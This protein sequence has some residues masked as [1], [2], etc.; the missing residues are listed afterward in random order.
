MVGNTEVIVEPRP[1]GVA[2]SAGK[3]GISEVDGCLDPAPTRLIRTIRKYGYI[4]SGVFTPVLAKHTKHLCL[5]I[6]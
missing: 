2:I 6:G 4:V 3:A 5:V 1:Q